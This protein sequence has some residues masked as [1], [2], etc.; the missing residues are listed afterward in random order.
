M[1]T[2]SKCKKIL[3]QVQEEEVKEIRDSLYAFAEILV[4]EYLKTKSNKRKLNINKYS[5]ISS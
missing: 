3:G 5:K 4:D 1:L 2:I